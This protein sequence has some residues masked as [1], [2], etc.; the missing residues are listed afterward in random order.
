MATE[1]AALL[2]GHLTRSDGQEDLC[3]LIWRPS[4]GTT[5]S[6]AIVSEVI[7]PKDGERLIHGNVS[8]TST[9]F[10]RAAARAAET[11]SGLALVH[12]HPNGKGWQGLSSEDHAAE[13]GHAGQ[14]V[15]LTGLPLLGLTYATGTDTYSARLWHRVG[16]RRY[17]PVWAE[18]VRCVGARI[19]ISW[20][21]EV[22]PIPPV[23][24]QLTRTVSAWGP[25]IH[26]DLTRLHVGII[27]AGSVGA[28]V[29]E[30]VARTGVERITVMDFDSVEKVNLDRL[31]HATIRDVHLARSKVEIL[32]RA[33]R[34]S[35]TA[36]NPDI[37]ALELSV[38]E[39]EGLARALDCD[40]L[41]SCVDRPWPRA[42]LNLA[43]YAHLIPVVDGGILI[44]SDGQRMRGAEWRAHIA[45][46]G[47][48]C[49]E[50][51]GQYDPADVS[52]ERSGLLDEPSYITGLDPDHPLR[53]GENVFAFSMSAA[54]NETLQLLTAVIAPNG[55]GDVGAH[56]HHFATGT[57]DRD[58]RGCGSGC[59]YAG[60]LLAS[61]D[62][63]GL[64]VTAR[65]PIA[66]T[67]RLDRRRRAGHLTTRIARS[68]DNLFWRMV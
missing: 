4:T 57:L 2:A 6:T 27:G 34:R 19:A 38:V 23:R 48:A 31:L 51:L 30:T 26:A 12:S 24:E 14:A 33:L 40:V 29:A 22:R 15:A 20:N 25:D 1:V 7:W 44:R 56:L 35:S 28:L 17:I 49:L 41:F 54:A 36:R 43:A 59:P 45:A 66:E 60:T 47:R 53:H 37:R 55:V 13:S 50:C 65:H 39:P 8:F 63:D 68:L 16:P 10:L 46:P 67:A 18:S 3:F 52:L 58:E 61:G 42:V 11:A 64:T 5:R 32:A 62:N 9:Y 21:D